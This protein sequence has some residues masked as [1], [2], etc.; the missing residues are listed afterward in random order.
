MGY[1]TTEPYLYKKYDNLINL[2]KKKFES[3]FNFMNF[4][5]VDGGITLTLY[6]RRISYSTG[7]CVLIFVLIGFVVTRYDY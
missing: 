5:S 2:I 1:R 3:R 6:K 7:E 4:S